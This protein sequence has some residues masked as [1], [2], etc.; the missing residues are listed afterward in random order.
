MGWP[1]SRTGATDGLADRILT[2][3]GQVK[4]L[5]LEWDDTF[6]RLERILGRLNKRAARAAQADAEPHDPEAGKG[7]V[8]GDGKDPF[9]EALDPISRQV[10]E[11]RRRSG[12]LPR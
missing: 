10:W 7:L 9:L 5:R 2:L 1:R 8:A 6:E 4:A 11:R 3:E 12:L